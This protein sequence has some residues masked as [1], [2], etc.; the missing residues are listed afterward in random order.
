MTGQHALWRGWL[1]FYQRLRFV[2]STLRLTRGNAEKIKNFFADSPV[3]R[4]LRT[5]RDLMVYLLQSQAAR[6]AAWWHNWSIFYGEKS[7]KIKYLPLIRSEADN[8]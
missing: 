8:S 1:D 7:G 4:H 2:A 3:L 5:T 6:E